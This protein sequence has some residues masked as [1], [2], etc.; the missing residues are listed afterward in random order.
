MQAAAGLLA[1]RVDD[2]QRSPSVE[3]IDLD[4]T[5]DWDEDR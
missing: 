2:A 4:A 5:D 3:K 1:T